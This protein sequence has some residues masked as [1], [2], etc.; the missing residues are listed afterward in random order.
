MAREQ[1]RHE[2]Y[3][4]RTDAYAAFGSEYTEVG[5]INDISLG[6]LSFASI[7]HVAELSFNDAVITIYLAGN[8]F[9]LPDLSCRMVHGTPVQEYKE[10]HHAGESIK[11]TMYG[12]EFGDLEEKKKEQLEVFV[13]SYAV[14]GND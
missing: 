4:L 14:S 2:R 6:G 8:G 12:V 9:Y 11:I 13:S 7:N 10:F 3:Q 1:R 5:K